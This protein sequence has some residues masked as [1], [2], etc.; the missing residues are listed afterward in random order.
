L[1]LTNEL[2]G[3]KKAGNDEKDVNADVTA[4]QATRPEVKDNDE[5]NGNGTQSLDVRDKVLGAR[6]FS[7][8][9]RT[10]HVFN[11]MRGRLF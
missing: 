4:S 3:N 9:L 1:K 7:R 6:F 2:A 8:F 10:T 5:E 11:P